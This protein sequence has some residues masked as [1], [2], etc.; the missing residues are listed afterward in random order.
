[1]SMS[2]IHVLHGFLSYII[3]SPTSVHSGGTKLFAPDRY[4]QMNSCHIRYTASYE[5]NGG[6]VFSFVL[7]AHPIIGQYIFI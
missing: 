6:T 3:V 7:S 2:D 4:Y 1:M 5:H